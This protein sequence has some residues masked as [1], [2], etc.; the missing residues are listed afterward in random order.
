MSDGPPCPYCGECIYVESEDIRDEF[1][2]L[3]GHCD[4]RVTIYLIWHL[5][6]TKP[7]ED[8]Y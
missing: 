6:A 4:E 1:E 7:D 5:E 8:L 3:C 2:Y